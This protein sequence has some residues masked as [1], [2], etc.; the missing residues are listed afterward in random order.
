M[1]YLGNVK[2]LVGAVGSKVFDVA[3]AKPANVISGG[4]SKVG[5]QSNLSKSKAAG[6]TAAERLTVAKSTKTGKVIIGG[7]G[8]TASALGGYAIG[9]A[10]LSKSAG[11]S[12][13]GH[14][15]AGTAVVVPASSALTEIA[16]TGINKPAL[17]AALLTGNKEIITAVASEE[18]ARS[19][20]I[21][22]PKIL[23]GVGLA[24][25]AGGILLPNLIKGSGGEA[26]TLEQNNLMPASPIAPNPLQPASPSIIPASTTTKAKQKRRK[27]IKSTP[28]F[29]NYNRVTIYNKNG[30]NF[31]HVRNS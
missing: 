11:T 6:Q 9:K 21:T 1:G 22:D 12:I 8:V 27:S 15:A 26:K 16:K 29:R 2:S 20:G 7:L 23:A 24:G 14:A 19:S 30:T 18:A 10:A 5:V 17:G 25:I 4:L 13:A 31:K 28:T 3:V